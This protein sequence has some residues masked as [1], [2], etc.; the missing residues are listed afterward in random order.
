MN[1]PNEVTSFFTSLKSKVLSEFNRIERKDKTQKRV[2]NTPAGQ[3]ELNIIRGNVFEKV[4]VCQSSKKR[5]IPDS[6][7]VPET[8]S[9]L[10]EDSGV[11]T[12]IKV[13]EICSH[14]AN[15]LVPVGTISLRYR[16][17]KEGRFGGG[18]DL[19]P[20]FPFE[21]DMDF[22][23]SEIQGVCKKY[24]KEYEPLRM[25]LQKSFWLKYRN[26][27]RGGAIGIAFDV[28]EEEF[29]FV[30]D[31]G[32]TFLKT[33]VEIVKKRKDEPF[34]EE[35]RERQLYKRG[36]WVEFNLVEDEGFIFGLEIGIDPEIM[37]LQTLPPILRF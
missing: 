1:I 36:R 8:M 25:A 37:I 29:E 6:S 13:F 15:P 27:P 5:K 4:S 28:P 31:L 18:T 10:K 26:E 35:Q 7:Y 22:Y 24:N 16:C 9:D 14:M 3:T 33:Y 21:E 2:W 30:K 11:D 20:I 23:R 17:A 32:E 34:T 19:S 12:I